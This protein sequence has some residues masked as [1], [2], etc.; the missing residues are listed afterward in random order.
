MLGSEVMSAKIAVKHTLTVPASGP[1]ARQVCP[2]WHGLLG[3]EVI[4]AV[5]R[6]VVGNVFGDHVPHVVYPRRED[7]LCLCHACEHRTPHL[8]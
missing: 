6:W 3:L 7:V 8:I 5:V 2:L 4:R 1:V